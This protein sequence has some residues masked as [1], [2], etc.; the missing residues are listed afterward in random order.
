M[1]Q[2][3]LMRKAVVII[4]ATACMLA[5]ILYTCIPVHAEGTITVTSAAE[6]KNAIQNASSPLTVN[7][8]GNI[9]TSTISIGSG[10]DI[11]IQMN[12]YQLRTTSMY[13]LECLGKLTVNGGTVI[14]EAGQ[15]AGCIQV[16]AGGTCALNGT[17][18]DGGS[19]VLDNHGTTTVTDS[20]ITASLYFG[21]SNQTSGILYLNGN[22]LISGE[23]MAGIANYG[24]IYFHSGIVKST[25]SAID[26]DAGSSLILPNGKIDKAGTEGRYNTCTV[27]DRTISGKVNGSADIDAESIQDLI[28][29]SKVNAADVTHLEITEGRVT[30]EDWRFL[31][32]DKDNTGAGNPLSHLEHLLIGQSVSH[33]A[34]IPADCFWGDS[35]LKEV[36]VY[37]VNEIGGNAFRNCTAL[38]TAM[39]PDLQKMGQDMLEGCTS[40]Q[41]FGVPSTPPVCTNGWIYTSQPPRGLQL[42]IVDAAGTPLAGQELNEARIRYALAFEDG[43][44]R[45]DGYWFGIDIGEITHTIFASGSEGGTVKGAG[46]V[47]RGTDARIQVIPDEGWKVASAEADGISVSVENNAYMFRDVKEDHSLTVTFEKTGDAG[48]PGTEDGVSGKP[49]FGAGKAAQTGDEGR[50]L[51]W[52]FL[53]LAASAVLKRFLP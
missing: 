46:K 41:V 43:S 5:A 10:K 25:G 50:P 49:A 44:D 4:G 53:L 37:G 27:A 36:V 2:K 30:G 45:E 33:A 7:L 24:T 52:S 32:S 35:T 39:F 1:R 9:F 6:L 28:R 17:K 47:L 40:M 11:T 23:R 12:G 3:V 14:N 34:G 22:S 42:Q 19:M 18:L 20:T 15:P 16:S 38:E 29:R 48:A 13:A 8:G 21:I 26:P 51:L 31:S